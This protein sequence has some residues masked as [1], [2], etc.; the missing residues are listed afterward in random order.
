M[1]RRK[2]EETKIIAHRED[3]RLLIW[4]HVQAVAAQEGGHISAEDGGKLLE[5]VTD[6][7]ESPT[8][9]RGSFDSSFLQLP[10]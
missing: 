9:L 7:V 5:E 1:F 10:M 3:R 6:L 4:E 8:V 2:L